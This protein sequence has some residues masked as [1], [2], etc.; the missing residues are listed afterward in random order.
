M[1]HQG[2]TAQTSRSWTECVEAD[3]ST[4]KDLHQETRTNS[5]EK[6]Q[7]IA[8]IMAQMRVFPMHPHRAFMRTVDTMPTIQSVTLSESSLDRWRK[9]P[10]TINSSLEMSQDMQMERP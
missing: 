3:K 1:E 9:F 7:G 2:M 4:G 8:V 5:A 10:T 6:Y